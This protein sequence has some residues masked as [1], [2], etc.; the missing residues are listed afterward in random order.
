MGQGIAGR[1]DKRPTVAQYLIELRKIFVRKLLA[2]CMSLS[3][4][5]VCVTKSTIFIFLY[6]MKEE[7][8][9]K[10]LNQSRQL[11]HSKT[12][13]VQYTDPGLTL[14]L[15][16]YKGAKVDK[17]SQS[18]DPKEQN[19]QN[20]TASPSSAMCRKNKMACFVKLPLHQAS[21]EIHLRKY[22]I[23]VS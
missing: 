3:A 6:S 16:I 5:I 23:R 7:G 18:S 10:L 22:L 4:G 20:T 2:T 15:E 12:P 1:T 11:S 9:Q 13:L 17:D 8:T 21:N 19:K 14:F